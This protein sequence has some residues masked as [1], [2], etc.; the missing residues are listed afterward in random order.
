MKRSWTTL[1]REFW[2]WVR[3]SRVLKATTSIYQLIAAQTRRFIRSLKEDMSTFFGIWNSLG[4][5]VIVGLLVWTAEPLLRGDIPQTNQIL[6][7][8]TAVYVLTAFNQMREARKNRQNH[9]ARPVL[10]FLEF[11]DEEDFKVP[12]LR[13]FGTSPAV[14]FQLLAQVEGIED[15][16]YIVRSIKSSADPANL[17]PGQTVTLMDNRLADELRNPSKWPNEAEL[18]LYYGFESIHAGD[19]PHAQGLGKS[20]YD[21]DLEHPN[22]KSFQLGELRTVLPQSDVETSTE[23]IR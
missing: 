17:E 16:P 18:N 3:E 9:E 2:I 21:L 11:D 12:K 20:L 14:M 5:L 13:N 19:A 6:V 7:L 10:P 22:P 8:L 1:K 15:G 23:V 4:V